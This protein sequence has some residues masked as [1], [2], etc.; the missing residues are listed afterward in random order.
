V[1][2][3]GFDPSLLRV[4]DPNSALR[5][6]SSKVTKRG[7]K[8]L[9]V[10]GEMACFFEKKMLNELLVYERALH[11]VLDVPMT[12]ICAYDIRLVPTEVF[13]ELLDAHSNAIFLGQESQLVAPA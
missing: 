9:R 1:E 13:R 8:G 11:R 10:T 12:A 4:R 7:Y 3:E 2:P 6:Q 5:L